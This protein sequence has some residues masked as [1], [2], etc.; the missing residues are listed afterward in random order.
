MTT[1]ALAKYHEAR[2]FHP[3][4]I[5]M[6]D[7]Q[8]LIVEQPQFLAYSPNSRIAT[9][10]FEDGSFELVDL[11]HITGLEVRRNGARRQ[12]RRG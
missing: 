10:Y 5:R 6:L 1:N 9:V 12:R 2:P 8:A 7:G 3:F 11:P 4:T